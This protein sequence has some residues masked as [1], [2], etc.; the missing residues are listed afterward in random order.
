[1]YGS[2][3]VEGWGIMKREELEEL[4]A[5]AKRERV[6][7]LY[8]SNKKIS[9][10]PDSIGDLVNLTVLDLEGNKLTTL[11]ESIGDLVNLKVL[12]LYRNRFVTLPESIGNLT[13]LTE[14]RPCKGKPGKGNLVRLPDS[15]GNLTNLRNLDLARNQLTELPDSIGNLVNLTHLDLDKNQLT[16]LPNSMGNLINLKYLGIGR[17]KITEIPEW[18]TNLTKLRKLYLSDNP[19]QD[20]TILQT[21]PKLKTVWFMNVGL[22]ARFR[23]KLSEWKPQWLLEETNVE[24]RRILVQ[25]VGYEKLCQELE[26]IELDSWREYTLLKLD[27][28]EKFFDQSRNIHHQEPMVL[29]KMTCPSTAHIHILRVPPDM[30]SAEAAITWVNHGLHPDDIAIAT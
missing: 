5:T 20:L 25:Q 26:A 1:M 19:L 23:T 3:L 6:S 27:D 18:I 29:L 13:D 15:I 16:K 21:L 10:L 22:P 4:I 7:K 12:N 30:T 2:L 14:L 28:L 8:L 9:V 11:P 17:N 24:I